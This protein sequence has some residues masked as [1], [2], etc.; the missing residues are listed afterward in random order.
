[1]A[2]AEQAVLVICFRTDKIGSK[3]YNIFDEIVK[4][5]KAVS[6]DMAS[7]MTERFFDTTVRKI[8]SAERGCP[9]TEAQVHRILSTNHPCPELLGSSR[10]GVSCKFF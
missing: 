2:M 9:L 10:F 4:L 8:K 1:M 3:S 7:A 6:M 5:T